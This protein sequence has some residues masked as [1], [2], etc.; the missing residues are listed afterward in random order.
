MWLKAIYW[1]QVPVM[2]QRCHD[3]RWRRSAKQIL[4]QTISQTRTQLQNSC[5][6]PFNHA[7]D[8]AADAH[9]L[10]HKIFAPPSESSGS[11]LPLTMTKYLLLSRWYHDNMMH[12]NAA[13]PVATV[14]AP[15]PDPLVT[16]ITWQDMMGGPP[17]S[18]RTMQWLWLV[19]LQKNATSL[20]WNQQDKIWTTPPVEERCSYWLRKNASDI[21]ISNRRL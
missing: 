5:E 7:F 15:L 17:T 1:Y 2:M 21:I 13:V 10:L 18:R 8:T 4:Q 20:W 11:F 12:G 16:L 9:P 3:M 19:L 6:L 14:T